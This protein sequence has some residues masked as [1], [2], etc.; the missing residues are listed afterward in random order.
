MRSARRGA[1]RLVYVV[2]TVWGARRAGEPAGTRHRGA[3]ESMGDAD[4]GACVAACRPGR[5][6]RYLAACGRLWTL[7]ESLGVDDD[8]DGTS[9]LV[10]ER[11][12]GR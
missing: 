5:I 8:D 12:H 6:G 1:P 3:N 7:G 4:F 9:S 10:L 11:R 2:R